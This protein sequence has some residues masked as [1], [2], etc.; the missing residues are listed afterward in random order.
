MKIE[1][2]EIGGKVIYKPF[3][4]NKDNP[5]EEGVITSKNDYYVFVRYGSDIYSKAT[6]AEHIEYI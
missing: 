4:V 1:D 6:R 3:T 5:I 2:A